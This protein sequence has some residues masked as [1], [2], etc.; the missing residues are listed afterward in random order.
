MVIGAISFKKDEKQRKNY[1]P[2]ALGA[3]V[4]TTA[5]GALY[6]NKSAFKENLDTFIK[7]ELGK[8]E[9]EAKEIV[10]NRR[11]NLLDTVRPMN[12]AQKAEYDAAVSR[13]KPL[14]ELRKPLTN[15]E[16]EYNSLLMETAGGRRT[17]AYGKS[18]YELKLGVSEE[19][20]NEVL[21]KK[22]E[23]YKKFLDIPQEKRYEIDAVPFERKR[24]A[25]LRHSNRVPEHKKVLTDI[26]LQYQK[27]QAKLFNISSFN[28]GT[29]AQQENS[30]LYRNLR[31][32]FEMGKRANTYK[33]GKIG[34]IAG[35]VLM[36]IAAV[37]ASVKPKKK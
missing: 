17:N 30:L 10:A 27:A 1:L 26:H 36:V 19:K 34:L 11:K 3:T 25:G 13:L 24:L 6:G 5:G 2:H 21:K 35:G 14:V 16:A 32:D 37:M 23:I 4:L 20:L 15:A 33:Y 12:S 8:Q 31:E 7:N 29:K 18:G 9:A 22:D 28:K